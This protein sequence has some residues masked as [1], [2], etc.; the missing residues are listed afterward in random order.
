[1]IDYDNIKL[2]KLNEAITSLENEVINNR[3]MYYHLING[4]MFN[5]AYKYFLKAHQ[6]EQYLI[7]LRSIREIITKRRNI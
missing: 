3:R 5:E 2:P 4:G 6:V 1:M 7:E